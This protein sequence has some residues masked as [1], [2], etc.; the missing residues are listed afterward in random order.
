[1]KNSYTS[2]GKIKRLHNCGWKGIFI[3]CRVSERRLQRRTSPLCCSM[4]GG[5]ACD[6]AGSVESVTVRRPFPLQHCRALPRPHP[7]T[8][9]NHGQRAGPCS[10]PGARFFPRVT[11]SASDPRVL[12]PSRSEVRSPRGRGRLIIGAQMGHGRHYFWSH[13]CIHSACFRCPG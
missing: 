3:F 10:L 5:A 2:D 13:D 4:C 1:M 6:H 12:L 9:M 7:N 8:R 11:K